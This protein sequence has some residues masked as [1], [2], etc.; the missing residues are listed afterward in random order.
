[1]LQFINSEELK[2]A[3]AKRFDL[4]KHYGID[5]TEER[6]VSKFNEY[7]NSNFYASS[8]LYESVDIEVIDVSPK[9]AQ[10]M[11]NAIVEE[12][13]KLILQ[14]K[15]NIV[16]EYVKTYSN[17]IKIKET[18]IDSIEAKLKYLRITYG[19]LD[20]KAQ[21]KIISKRLGKSMSETDNKILKG[22]QEYGGEYTILQ[23]KLK[24]ETNSYKELKLS[25]DKN[26]LDFNG[27]LSYTTV[28]SKAN[29][30]DKK[31]AP[32]RMLIVVLFTLSSL[33]LALTILLFNTKKQN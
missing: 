28:V 32:L 11:A 18:E 13:N 23:N 17:Q 19:L 1:L 27:K 2:N 12:T 33:L 6:A 31:C 10:S 25:Y 15:K 8:T 24:V 9:L 26:L 7:Y 29:L 3:M 22:L 16:G 20:V 5:S 30:P 21:S 14:T 4:Y